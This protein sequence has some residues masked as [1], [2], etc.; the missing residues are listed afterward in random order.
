MKPTY[1][2]NLWAT[3][4]D[5]ELMQLVRAIHADLALDTEPIY[6]Q[7]PC[8]M[9]DAAPF[10]GINDRVRGINFNSRGYE[11]LAANHTPAD[12]AANVPR[13][14]AES[15]FVIL[16]ELVERLQRI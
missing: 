14:C 3:T 4:D 15:A 6:Q 12:D 10:A 7:A 13:D 8:W 2:P 9:N 1:G 11:T 5:A 16:R